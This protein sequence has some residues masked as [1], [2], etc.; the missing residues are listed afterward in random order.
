MQAAEERA[1]R[2]LGSAVWREQPLATTL[3]HELGLARGSGSALLVLVHATGPATEL[4][5]ELL[6][7]HSGVLLEGTL[8]T[9]AR[10][11][12]GPPPVAERGQGRALWRSPGDDQA[13]ETV[14]TAIRRA[15]PGM[16]APSPDAPP[17]VLHL[18]SHAEPLGLALSVSGA[19]AGSVTHGLGPSLQQAALAVLHLCDAATQ[20]GMATQLLRW[21]VPACVAPAG[22]LGVEAAG[23]FCAGLAS[24]GRCSV[25]AAVRRGRRAVAALSSPFPDQRWHRIQLWVQSAQAARHRLAASGRWDDGWPRPA[26]SVV[27]LYDE[28]LELAEDSDMGFVGLEHLVLAESQHRVVPP[29]IR[30]RLAT[31]AAR[32]RERLGALE[33]LP[34]ATRRPVPT[35]RLAH[36]LSSLEPQLDRAGLW[37]FL[38]DAHTDVMVWMLGGTPSTGSGSTQTSTIAVH[39]PAAT[40]LEVLGGPE[41]GRVLDLSPHMV[42]GRSS[43]PARADVALYAHTSVTDPHLSRRHL[44]WLGGGEVELLRP[45][46]G[47]SGPMPG[48]D[49]T[50][51]MRASET[52]ALSPGTTLRA[53]VQ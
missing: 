1:G 38:F 46:H 9:V 28:A 6:V 51:Q 10:L 12:E 35:P 5:W 11:S 37:S 7:D 15:D 3:A 44:R 48:R 29:H 34:S 27:Q 22:R 30:H 52:L 36:I 25:A 17:E 42:L 14:C 18:V 4:P 2:A 45:A 33:L 31:G 40:R 24:A 26:A 47:A 41:D 13:V 50:W 32:I 20:G 39:G 8:A 53:I 16:G 21:G 19:S 23:A 49:G 43:D